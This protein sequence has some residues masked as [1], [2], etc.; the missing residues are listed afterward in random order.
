MAPADQ[1]V[2]DIDANTGTVRMR[3]N[4][5]GFLTDASTKAPG[6]I[7]LGYVQ[8]NHA[9]ARTDPRRPEHVPPGAR[10]P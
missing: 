4:L 2:T 3:V 9:D 7:A 1:T 8:T 10:L 6:K 5:D